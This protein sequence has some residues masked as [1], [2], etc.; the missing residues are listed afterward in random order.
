[1]SGTACPAADS[2]VNDWNAGVDATDANGRT[3]D[4]VWGDQ[5]Y[6]LET[7]ASQTGNAPVQFAVF[8]REQV[9][10]Q[11]A[12]R[13][14]C[15]FATSGCTTNATPNSGDIDRTLYRSE[16]QGMM[17]GRYLIANSGTKYPVVFTDGI[18]IT[19]PS[20]NVLVTDMFTMPITS[21]GRR[22]LWYEYFDMSNTYQAEYVDATGSSRILNNGMYRYYERDN[23]PCSQISLTSQGRL[24]L[25][26]PF[27]A[28][29]INGIRFQLNAQTPNSPY[30]DETHL[31]VD[32]GDT[33]RSSH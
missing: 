19:H 11:M 2:N 29:R 3:L 16:F 4:M 17:Q 26:Y 9:F 27:L 5:M 28:G 10:R 12:M 23:G 30:A 18:E 8:I 13:I 24:R 21:R 6:Y 33:Y 14:A 22:A 31:Y 25:D 32:G 7:R 15:T 1:M 20:S